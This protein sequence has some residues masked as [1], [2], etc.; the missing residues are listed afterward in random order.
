MKELSREQIPEIMIL[1]HLGHIIRYQVMKQMEKYKL[2]PGQAGI[3]FLLDHQGKMA[4]K[5]LA[6][7]MCIKPP[8]ITVALQKLEKTD[9]IMREADE[10][11]QRITR[12]SLTEQGKACVGGI[13]EAL[14][15][16]NEKMLESF[17]KEETMLLKKMLFQIQDNFFRQL[18]ASDY[19]EMMKKKG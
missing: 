13:K 19:E 9:Y 10:K 18:E 11:D 7:M 12:I 14:Q 4:Q 1:D 3:L 16:A 17:T 8:S 5:E 15:I 6:K 2:K